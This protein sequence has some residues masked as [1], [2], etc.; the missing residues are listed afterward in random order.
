MSIEEQELHLLK[1]QTNIFNAERLRKKFSEKS[2][3]RLRNSIGYAIEYVKKYSGIIINFRQNSNNTEKNLFQN[4]LKLENKII[5]GFF[6]IMEMLLGFFGLGIP[7][8]YFFVAFLYRCCNNNAM[9]YGC[10]PY[11]GQTH[12]LLNYSLVVYCSVNRELKNAEYNSLLKNMD[13]LELNSHIL[14]EI[15]KSAHNGIV[16]VLFAIKL[17]QGIPII[18]AIAG[19]LCWNEFRKMVKFERLKFERIYEQSKNDT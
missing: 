1:R 2:Q 13:K 8:L 4:S 11:C 17:L 10:D 14:K 5:L 9:L 3:V 15:D 12:Y 18:G 6:L 19:I 16:D 7:N